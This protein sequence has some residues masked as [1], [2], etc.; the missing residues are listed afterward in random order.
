VAVSARA[1]KKVTVPAS[2]G[3]RDVRGGSSAWAGTYPF[4]V[5]E[6]AFTGW[7]SHDLHQLEYA[8][9][10]VAQVETATA[11]YLLPPQQAVWIPAGVEHCTTL[12]RVRTVSAFFE[13]A[14]GTGVREQVRILSASPLIREMLLY[15]RRWPI[16]RLSADPTA[17]IFFRALLHLIGEA[18]DQ[19][20]PLRLP[21]SQDPLVAA[22]MRFTTDNLGWVTLSDACVATGT[23]ERS[24][25]RAFAA[26]TGMSWREYLLQSRL[27]RAMALLS[28]PE[29]TVLAIA[30][31][32]GFASMSGLPGRS[33]G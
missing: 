1:A 12:T 20:P 15:A 17:D 10:G 8:F 23:S 30:T 27:L 32:V 18:L 29:P 26:A 25:R 24:L 9:E 22:V 16:G 2:I 6:E 5:G 31:S 4:E 33:A 7:H 13:P 14:P 19:E 21:V 11:R 28:Q 3:R